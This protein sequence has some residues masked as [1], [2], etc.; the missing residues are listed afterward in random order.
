MMVVH[1]KAVRMRTDC[2]SNWFISE[3]RHCIIP[4]IVL[5]IFFTTF[6][7]DKYQQE[8][9]TPLLETNAYQEGW[10]KLI[11]ASTKSVKTQKHADSE[12]QHD[13]DCSARIHSV[14]ENGAAMLTDDCPNIEKKGVLYQQCF[15]VGLSR[16]ARFT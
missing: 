9:P 14:D 4:F 11:G 1:L 7:G 13:G 5:T 2:L 3:S 12:V 15:M 10:R 6:A 8:I 16:Q